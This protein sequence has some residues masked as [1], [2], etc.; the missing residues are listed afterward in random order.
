MNDPTG[1]FSLYQ[2]IGT[3]GAYNFE[4]FTINNKY[5]LAVANFRNAATYKLDSVI[6]Q[7]NG[8]QF[9]AFQHIGTSGASSFTFFKTSK[10][11]EKLFL[12]VTN[13]RN[14]N[15]H[16]VNSVIYQWNNNQFEIFQELETEGAL[17][18]TAFE[19]NSE[20]FI[21]FANFYNS[22][23][24]HSVQSTLFKLSEQRFE[25]LQTFQTYGARG[26]NS[27]NIDGE[28]FLAFANYVNSDSFIYK[29]DGGKFVLFQSIPAGKAIA[30]YPFVMCG[31]TYLGMANFVFEGD[32]VVYKF[33]GT[34]FIKYQEFRNPGAFDIKSFVYKSHTYLVITNYR[35]KHKKFDINSK[36]YKWTLI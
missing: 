16:S 15:T 36:V 23:Q 1:N 19:I 3:S 9:V 20:I 7:W 25:K 5:Y 29:W 33:S 31:Q 27:F 26:V 35:N 13:H 14:D 32:S 8:Q 22:A 24:K 10:D 6:Y 2:T 12:V 28:T 11:E 4:S 34:K 21:A 18:S 30:W 17:E